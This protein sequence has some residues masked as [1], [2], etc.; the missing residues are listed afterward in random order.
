M[1]QHSGAQALAPVGK[2]SQEPSLNHDDNHDLVVIPVGKA[3]DHALKDD[4]E[5]TAAGPCSEL[6]GEISTEDELFTK[7][8]RRGES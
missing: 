5:E 3:K 7:A 2:Q 8:A 4:S 6:L 1:G